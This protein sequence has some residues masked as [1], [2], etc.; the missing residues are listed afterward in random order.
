MLRSVRCCE[1]AL[2]RRPLL[3]F[4]RSRRGRYE[5]RL[6]KQ[7][8]SVDGLVHANRTC[9]PRRVDKAV[10]APILQSATFILAPRSGRSA[11]AGFLGGNGR[12]TS[13]SASPLTR[14]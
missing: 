13:L 6:K 8:R 10:H 1:V 5:G 2:K 9:R 4:P 11:R 7:D 14:P 12:K 3:P